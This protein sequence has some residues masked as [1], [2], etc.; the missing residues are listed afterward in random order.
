MV[1]SVV[2]AVDQPLCSEQPPLSGD[3]FAVNSQT[4]QSEEQWPH[5]Q[6]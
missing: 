4:V 6:G 3:L 1:S 2:I 5:A